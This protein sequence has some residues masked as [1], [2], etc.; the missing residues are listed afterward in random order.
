MAN[1]NTPA[2]KRDKEP[3]FS[4]VFTANA[5]VNLTNRV[6][7]AAAGGAPFTG[8][9]QV[10]PYQNASSGAMIVAHAAASAITVSWKDCTGVARSLAAITGLAAGAVIPLPFAMTELTIAAN[11]TCSVVVFWHGNGANS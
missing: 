5:T 11:T 4:E 3:P 10:A 8:T 2:Q 9:Q 1:S 6:A 7:V